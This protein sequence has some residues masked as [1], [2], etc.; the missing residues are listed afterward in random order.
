MRLAGRLALPTICLGRVTGR[1]KRLLSRRRRHRPAVTWDFEVGSLA[2]QT[3]CPVKKHEF[4]TLVSI[5]LPG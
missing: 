5:R 1:A 2:L 3:R 4:Q